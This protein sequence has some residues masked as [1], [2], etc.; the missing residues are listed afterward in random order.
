MPKTGAFRGLGGVAP[1]CL[2]TA[3]ASPRTLRILRI[4]LIRVVR[5]LA[6]LSRACR[7]L[8]PVP[9]CQSAVLLVLCRTSPRALLAEKGHC[10][11][12]YV[13]GLSYVSHPNELG[14]R[15]RGG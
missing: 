6:D 13:G 11:G 5:P 8:K 3:L 2:G 4:G 15:V 14:T 7:P 1:I 9:V 10:R 12:W